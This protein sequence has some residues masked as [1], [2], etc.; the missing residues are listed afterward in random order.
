[1]EMY[2][3]QFASR[4]QSMLHS[5]FHMVW[6]VGGFRSGSVFC[7]SKIGKVIKIRT[8]CPCL[9][10]VSVRVLLVRVQRSVDR[11]DAGLLPGLVELL[12]HDGAQH[13]PGILL[14]AGSHPAERL[15]LP[16]AD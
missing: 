15:L 2:R 8:G 7:E 14:L 16:G 3:D 9:H 11:G 4:K 6:V 1:M 5:S 10:H 13:V 12:G